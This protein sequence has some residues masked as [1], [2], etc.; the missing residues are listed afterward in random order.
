MAIQ[1]T[2]M[3]SLLLDSAVYEYSLVLCL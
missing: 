1:T 3:V 2:W